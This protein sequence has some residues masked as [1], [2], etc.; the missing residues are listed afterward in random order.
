MPRFLPTNLVPK[1]PIA[2]RAASFPASL[3]VLAGCSAALAGCSTSSVPSRPPGLPPTPTSITRE[4]PGGDAADPE[5]AALQRLLDEPWGARPDRYNTLEVPLVDKKTWRRV[6]IWNHPTRA[7][8]RYGDKHW[9]V[10]TVLY[11]TTTGPGDPD[12]CLDEFWSKH[13]PLAEAYGV[14]LGEARIVRT[15]QDIDGEVRPL[16][17]KVLD[18]SVDS[19]FASDEYAGAIAAYESWPGTCLVSALAVKSTNHPDLARKVRDR[20]VEEGAAKLRWRPGI[21]DAPKTDAR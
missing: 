12:S 11:G 2:A 21:T 20:W 3:A 10:T 9:A 7:T 1:R 13:A 19:V 17:F 15:T 18:G 8:Y 6:R 4:N 16:L 14:R 5:R